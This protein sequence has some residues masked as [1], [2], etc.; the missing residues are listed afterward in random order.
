MNGQINNELYPK[1]DEFLWM[2]FELDIDVQTWLSP[3]QMPDVAMFDTSI[4]PKIYIMCTLF[5]T[6]VWELANLHFPLL[7]FFE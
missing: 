6:H 2:T 1:R 5:L 4:H 3:F 7:N